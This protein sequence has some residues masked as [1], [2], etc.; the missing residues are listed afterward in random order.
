M[1]FVGAT[2]AGRAGSGIAA[3][4]LGECDRQHRRSFVCDPMLVGIQDQPARVMADAGRAGLRFGNDQQF[5]DDRVPAA[6]RGGHH[7]DTRTGIFQWPICHAH[8]RVRRARSVVLLAVA[9]DRG[10]VGSNRSK[11]FRIPED[12]YGI[13]KKFPSGISAL[14][15]I[16]S[17]AC[18][19]I[20]NPVHRH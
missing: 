13:S 12:Q 7:L 8:V 18:L 6:V 15:L 4:V 14:R 20:S 17:L 9:I 3:H 11:L 10:F 2:V 16:S 5:R 1:E 19:D